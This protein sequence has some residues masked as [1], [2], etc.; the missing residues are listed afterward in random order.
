MLSQ[1]LQPL[2]HQQRTDSQL[3][4]GYHEGDEDCFTE[5]AARYRWLIHTQAMR[6][7]NDYH[8]AEDVVQE[9]LFL[10]SEVR[11]LLGYENFKSLLPVMTHNYIVNRYTYKK[12]NSRPFSLDA[13]ETRQKEKYL[14]GR[15]KPVDAD[16]CNKDEFSVLLELMNDL[17][18]PDQEALRGC[19]VENLTPKELAVGLK[20]THA[21]VNIRLGKARNRLLRIF[22]RRS[23]R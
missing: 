9:V 15:E 7:L 12:R 10:F 8:E 3:I 4:D 21:A 20:I 5:L 18:Q 16:L 2:S 19:Y 11:M 17:P 1:S 14:L 22:L 13:L 6:L 23:N